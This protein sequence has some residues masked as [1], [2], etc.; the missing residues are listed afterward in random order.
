MHKWMFIIVLNFFF[1]LFLSLI[2]GVS[3]PLMNGGP[4]TVD[5]V[6]LALLWGTPVATVF[7][8][9]CPLMQWGV[10]WAMALGVKPDSSG[11]T[12]ARDIFLVTIMFLVMG[13]V[14]TGVMT[15]WDPETYVARWL[16]VIPGTW[17]IAYVLSLI[18]EPLCFW[19]AKII[20]GGVPAEFAPPA[21]A[22]APA[23]S[24]APAAEPKA[25]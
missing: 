1:A 9:V 24:A 10:K 11:M 17:P 23:T 13:L 16:G 2:L 21:A 7:S 14:L 19:L 18:V 22:E 4:L 15:G 25:A 12:F 20:T 5:G 6:M 8:T 3:L